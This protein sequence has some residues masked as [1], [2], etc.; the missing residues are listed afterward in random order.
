MIIKKCFLK[1]SKK[2]T[3]DISWKVLLVKACL[4]IVM[5]VGGYGC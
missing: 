3:G 5:I 2:L 1:E 4:D